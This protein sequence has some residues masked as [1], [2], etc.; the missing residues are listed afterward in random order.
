MTSAIPEKS[1]DTNISGSIIN[2]DTRKD[3][4]YFEKYKKESKKWLKFNSFK[5]IP[6][7][8]WIKSNLDNKNF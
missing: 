6:C 8:V 7:L 3:W 5:Q 2:N 1:V 4:T